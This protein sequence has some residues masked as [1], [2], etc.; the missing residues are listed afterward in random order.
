MLVLVSMYSSRN[1]TNKEGPLSFRKI[2]LWRWLFLLTGGFSLA[3]PAFV[4]GDEKKPLPWKFLAS[5]TGTLDAKWQDVISKDFG[6]EAKWDCKKAAPPC[7]PTPDQIENLVKETTGDDIK[8]LKSAYVLLHVVDYDLVAQKKPAD[9]W[10]L[11]RSRDGKWAEPRWDYQKF[12]GQ[13]IYGSPS[14]LFIF[15]HLNVKVVSLA[16]AT[17]A[18]RDAINAAREAHKLN[19]PIPNNQIAKFVEALPA[20]KKLSD[21]DFEQAVKANAFRNPSDPAQPF[22]VNIREQ[23]SGEQIQWLGDYGVQ[24][25]FAN[26]HYEAAVVKRTPA[27]VANALS[28]FKIFAQSRLDFV[29][30]PSQKGIVWGAGRITEV[31]L[32]SDISV[33]GYS[34]AADQPLAEEERSTKQIGAVGAYNDEQMYWWDASIGIPVHKLK[35][36]QYSSSNNTVVAREVDRQSAY[37]MFNLMPHPVDLSDPKMNAWPRILAGFPLSSSPWDSLFVGGGVGIPWKPVQ[38][39]QFFVGATFLV[40]EHAKTLAAGSPADNAQLQN[41]LKSQ[42]KPK[43]TFGINVPVKSVIDKLLK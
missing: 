40:S 13:R 43:L 2:G 29:A 17:K 10:F 32:P 24:S 23:D 18:L 19:T 11:Y 39:F 37:A 7:I 33:A 27:N 21:S 41:D 3:L 31:G 16:D 20:D 35:D 25:S 34:Q 36:L 15:L 42:T 4:Q 22:V 8:K 9:K 28:L 6:T 38:N 30:V 1:G 14:I 12:T 26:V 5:P